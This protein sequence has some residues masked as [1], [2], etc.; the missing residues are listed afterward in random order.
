M[1]PIGEK[2]NVKDIHYLPSIY[3]TRSLADVSDV[4]AGTA[5]ILITSPVRLIFY[6]SH[7]S[8]Y[9]SLRHCKY[10]E[11]EGMQERK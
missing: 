10:V 8:A 7:F 2:M 4:R 6:E 1:L 5:F 3:S 9:I 11:N